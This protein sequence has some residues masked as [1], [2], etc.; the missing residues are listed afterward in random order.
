[1]KQAK[2]MGAR[3]RTTLALVATAWLIA[4]CGGGDGEED[5]AAAPTASPPNISGAPQTQVLV[6]QAYSFVPT[7]TDPDGGPFTFDIANRPAWLTFNASTG[8]LS[9][10]PTAADVGTYRNITIQVTDGKSPATLN[11]FDIQVLAAGSASVTLSWVP[12]TQNE[13]GSPLTDLAGYKIRYGGTSGSY[14]NTI[15]VTNPGLATYVIDGLLP[16][17]Y[18]FVMSSVNSRGV[19]SSHSNEAVITL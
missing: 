2:G 8:A 5:A 7:V 10:T 15:S 14:P 13:D 18:Y 19:E 16:T 9:G 12:P 11:P 4:G 17:K 6:N 3:G 1:M